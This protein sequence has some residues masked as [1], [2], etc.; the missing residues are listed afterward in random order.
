MSLYVPVFQT[1]YFLTKLMDSPKFA[2]LLGSGILDMATLDTFG[3]IVGDYVN[4]PKNIPVPDFTRTDLTDTSAQTGTA[5]G[6]DNQKY[7]LLWDDTLSTFLDSDVARTSE[8]YNALLSGRV[9]EKLAKRFL[10]RFG[11]VLNGAT[12][13]AHVHDKTGTKVTVEMIR[14]AKFKAGD[15][16]DEY[17]TL[18]CHSS[19]WGSIVKDMLDTYK[20]NPSIA[21]V[22]FDG[23]TSAILGLTQ[24]IITDQVPATF[25][26]D[27][28]SHGDDL[29]STFICRPGAVRLGY[30]LEP[31]VDYWRDIRVKGNM[32]YFKVLTSCT[33][34]VEATSWTAGANP[35]DSDLA[36]TANWT[37]AYQ[38]AREVGVV[39]ILSAA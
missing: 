17:T 30:Q 11:K 36:N 7:P 22:A 20:A 24:I 29:F 1:S 38:D 3:P 32:N 5:V 21:G 14:E 27:A 9:G 35:S 8:D 26:L 37:G 39:K 16:A 10:A 4:I 19:V 25:G 34:G 15:S 23:R 33:M 6:A 12:P 13:T 18:V 28:G 2:Q 31:K